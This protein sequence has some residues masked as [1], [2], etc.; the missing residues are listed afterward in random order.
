MKQHVGQFVLVVTRRFWPLAG[1]DAWRWLNLASGLQAAGYAPRILT[2]Q[3]HAAW[4]ASVELR[5]LGVHRI[6]PSPSTS[7]RSRRYT[8]AV[9][10]WIIDH[11]PQLRCVVI[12]AQEE[13]AQAVV[14]CCADLRIPSIVRYQRDDY[15]LILWQQQ[16]SRRLMVCRRATLTVTPS[17]QGMR[18]LASLDLPADRRVVIPDGPLQVFERGIENRLAARRALADINYELFLRAE[19]RLIVCP[20]EFNRRSALD[21]LI[22]VIGPVLE[23]KRGVKCWIIGD[24]PDRERLYGLICRGGWRSDI[25]LPGTFEDIET[26]I[27]AADGCILPS[28]VQG[29][30]FLLP[31]L[32]SSGVPLIACDSPAARLG[33]NQHSS[34]QLLEPGSNEDLHEKLESFFLQT[35]RWDQLA[36]AAAHSGPTPTQIISHWSQVLQQCRWWH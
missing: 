34:L 11:A 25:L 19:D 7:F 18:D 35:R 15:S 22:G 28:A 36:C 24:G 23:T 33:K 17:E 2:A 3:W 10:A 26:V 5:D 1:D 31:A 30:S 12:D 32:L 6:G 21:Y 14:E 29:Q 4:P 27:S 13:D 20:A 16:Q 9:C 8:R